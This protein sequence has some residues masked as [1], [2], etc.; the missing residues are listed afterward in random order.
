[1]Y[2]YS[3]HQ[4]LLALCSFFFFSCID[5]THFEFNRKFPI[6]FFTIVFIPYKA[7]QKNGEMWKNWKYMAKS[8]RKHEKKYTQSKEIIGLKLENEREK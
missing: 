1:M 5:Y 6:E 4:R 2:I 8:I 3:N 7:K